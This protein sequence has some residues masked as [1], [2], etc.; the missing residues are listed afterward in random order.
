MDSQF[1]VVEYRANH[2]EDEIMSFLRDIS[3]LI[4]FDKEGNLNY[5]LVFCMVVSFVA[6]GVFGAYLSTLL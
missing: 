2:Q 3:G 4:L 6:G 1:I 5:L